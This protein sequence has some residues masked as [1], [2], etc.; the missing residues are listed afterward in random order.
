MLRKA[1]GKKDPVMMAEQRA[2][3][4]DGATAGFCNVTLDDGRVVKVHR[5]SPL[6][7]EEDDKLYTIEEIHA[8]G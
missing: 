4:V 1:M 2:K 3:F 7:V 5:K 8:K 6:R